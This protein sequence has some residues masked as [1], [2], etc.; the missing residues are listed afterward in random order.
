MSN[1]WIGC[2][3]DRTL[4]EYDDFVSP[5]HIG[6]PIERMVKRIQ[7]HLANGDEVRIVTARVWYPEGDEKRKT[8][9]AQAREA[10]TEWCEKHIGQPL[11]ITCCKDY[12]MWLL[13]DDRAIQVEPNTGLLTTDRAYEDGFCNGLTEGHRGPRS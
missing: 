9:A 8:E 5:T 7:Q 13:Y 3:L 6:K 10:I 11:K 12:S 1:G 2:D 4:A